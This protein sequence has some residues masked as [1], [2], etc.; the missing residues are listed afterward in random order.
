MDYEVKDMSAEVFGKYQFATQYNGVWYSDA[1]FTDG[2]GIGKP[3]PGAIPAP[4]QDTPELRAWAKQMRENPPP[5]PPA[6]KSWWQRLL[7]L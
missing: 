5:P 3:K 7:G 4:F 1:D 2:P 6:A